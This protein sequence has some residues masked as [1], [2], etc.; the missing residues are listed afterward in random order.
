MGTITSSQKHKWPTLAFDFLYSVI[1]CLLFLDDFET[2][3]IL[4][5]FF[6]KQ[7]RTLC[8]KKK[9]NLKLGRGLT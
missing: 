2:S 3:N 9:K 4:K 8:V 6:K 5:F 1:V 7:N